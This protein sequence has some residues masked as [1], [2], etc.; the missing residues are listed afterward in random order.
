MLG[1]RRRGFTL[2]ELAVTL[3][4][5]AVLAALA[6]DTMRNSAP[7]ATFN[8]V[9]AEIQSLVHQAR[10]QALSEGQSVAVIVFPNYANPKGSTGRIVVVE[11]TS[12]PNAVMTL[13]TAALNISNYNPA[14]FASPTGI[15]ASSLSG[16]FITYLD[17]PRNVVVGPSTGL[18]QPNLPF[19]YNN[20]VVNQACSFCN[21]GG[22]NRGAIVFDP[23]GRTTF[24]NAAG[25]KLSVSGGSFSIYTTQ[26]GIKTVYSSSTLVITSP[27]G[28]IMSFN[29][30]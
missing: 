13:P 26:L 29:N 25:N 2:I 1:T 5:I 7:R 16:K 18:G 15:A 12:D 4:I 20:I 28:S 11:D 27:Y 23:R 21:T 8:G 10:Q 24:Y 30:G 3:T 6:F 14:V 22:D 9:A 19:P 17:L